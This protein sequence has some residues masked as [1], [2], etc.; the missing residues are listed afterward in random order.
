MNLLIQPPDTFNSH[1]LIHHNI[2]NH[3][4]QLTE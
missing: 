1:H 2:L 3:L 4:I